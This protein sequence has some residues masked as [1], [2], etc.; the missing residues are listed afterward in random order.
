MS[1]KPLN[2]F[3]THDLQLLDRSK[4]IISQVM[5]ERQVS[6][7][8]VTFLIS[9]FAGENMIVPASPE[10]IEV[11]RQEVVEEATRRLNEAELNECRGGGTLR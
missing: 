6:V 9:R 3:W 11:W 1:E 5:K 7:L 10:A 8:G 2:K 4:E